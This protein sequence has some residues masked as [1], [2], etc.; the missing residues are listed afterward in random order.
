MNI[1][2]DCDYTIITW[3][4]KLRPG[5]TEIFRRLTEDGH[6][7]YV[8]SGAGIRWYEVRTHG[9]ERYVTD[10]FHKPLYDYHRRMKDLGVTIMPDMVI[11]DYPDIVN[12]L[13]G[14]RVK[15]YVYERKSDTEMDRVYQIITA[16]D[17]KGYSVGAP[18][19]STQDCS[20]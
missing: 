10:C 13:G 8:W 5:V 14:V 11:D 4:G 9:L 12:A 18:E 16:F 15:P 17:A 19:G 7:I 6:I 2:F 3:D 1:F 20:G